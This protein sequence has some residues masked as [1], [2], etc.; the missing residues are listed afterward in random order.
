MQCVVDRLELDPGPPT[1][2]ARRAGRNLMLDREGPALERVLEGARRGNGQ[3]LVLR[4]ESGFGKSTLLD[5]AV[6]IASGLRVARVCGVEGEQDL[7][8]AA[9]HRLCTPMLDRVERLPEPQRDALAAAFGESSS[10]DIERFFL[11]L[12]VLGLL[13]EVSADQ[14]LVCVIDDAH[15]LD[16][17][18]MRV[19]AFAARRL[20]MNH[21]ALV[22][23]AREA[24]PELHGIPE[25][26]LRGL[27]DGEAHALLVAAIPGRLD[28]R[29]RDRVVA[30][31][32]GNAR[33]LLALS[34]ATAAEQLAGG[35]GLPVAPPA[36][37]AH[38]ECLTARVERLEVQTRRLLLL[39]A[40][41]PEGD[42]A[43]LWRA[44]ARLGIDP[45]AADEA[46]SAGFLELGVR[47]SFCDLHMRS[48]AYHCA[49][50][51]ERRAAHQALADSID[52]E[53]DPDRWAW[54]RAHATLA[55][56]AEI[57]DDLE[58]AARRAGAVGGL[59]AE[60]AFLERSAL[61]T[62]EPSRR[63]TR[64]LAAAHS[65][66]DAGS[67]AAASDLLAVAD[68]GPLVELE[69]A[70]LDRLRAKI[71]FASNRGSDAPR[72]LLEAAKALTPLDIRLARDTYLEAL[73]AA[74]F[75]GSLGG[76]SALRDAAEAARAAP[77]AKQPCS[78]DMLLDGL[79]VRFTDGHV[80]AASM[81]RRAVKTICDVDDTGW[82][83]LALCGAAEVWDIEAMLALASRYIRLARDRGALTDLPVA[84]NYAASLQVHD[85][86]LASAASLIEE[87]EGISE[88]TGQ[89]VAFGS[90]VLAVWRGSEAEASELI[91]AARRD[92]LTRNDGRQI[93]VTEFTS[94][95]LYN[96]LGRYGDALV[97]VIG[98]F[99]REELSPWILPELI[100]AA[101]R[102]DQPLLA[103]KAG[104]Q[105]VEQT[106]A[107]GTEWALGME[108]RSIALL[109]DGPDAEKL[110][111]A[112]IERLGRC[113]AAAHLARAHLLYGEWLRR[114]SRRLAA[115]EQLRVAHDM[116]S[117]MGAG[118]FAGRA[119][120]ELVATGERVRKRT[121]ETAN[122]LTPQEAQ[123]A[124]LAGD[125][126]SNAEIATRLYISARTVEY[127]L[128]KVF[129]KLGISSRVQIAK[130]LGRDTTPRPAPE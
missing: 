6:S 83:G 10:G 35:F 116:F 60:A 118:P 127:H 94:A 79:A 14:P 27:T 17:P 115:R 54:H 21:V 106:Q 125:G 128:H 97:A 22:F 122:Q 69:R 77:P 104:E 26:L 121:V 81:L 13:A 103:A 88:A 73:E 16:E 113:P 24:I 32:K 129:T 86:R 29:V 33:A 112:A 123:I 68:A 52:A 31:A 91:E 70:R 110:Y 41:E 59:A 4:G 84:L 78:A 11:G 46:A 34:S 36:R 100:E 96:G 71:A 56:D 47:V 3:A 111:R 18:S 19:L 92:A 119:H 57:A 98:A 1:D 75:A 25:L 105:L 89:R 12:A 50:F 53:V 120:R 30:E 61:L 20:R 102:S 74:V 65:K 49:P 7:S 90:L 72:L 42:S 85:G 55:P 9:L 87:A 80:A 43:V 126:Q 108:A 114:Q 48:V 109:T 15:L 130:V 107:S 93:A 64:A 5:H 40:A 66:F 38:T 2:L 76:A 63:A 39:A 45:G 37:D 51:G 44:A 62:P 8:Y 28:A 95:V 58:R 101:A 99:E 117:T 67:L 82:R 23:A 124:R